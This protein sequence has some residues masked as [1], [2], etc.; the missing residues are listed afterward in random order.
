MADR[1][2]QPC[3]CGSAAA[4]VV[5]VHA[6]RLHETSCFAFR[7]RQL[8]PRDQFDQPDALAAE[9]AAGNLCRRHVGEH[10]QQFVDGQRCN[11]LAEQHARRPLARATCSAPCTSVVTSRASTRCASRF[12]GASASPP[13]ARRSSSR[14]R[15]VKHFRYVD[16]VAIV[17]VQPELIELEGDVRCGSSHIVPASVFPNLAPDAVFISGQTSPWAFCA[18]QLADQIDAGGDVAPLVA[19]AHLQHAAIPIEQLQKI[20]GL[21]HE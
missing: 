11:V 2:R 16:D 10:R 20:V 18:A 5:H 19:A 7:R 17:G 1:P 12:S 14:S 3:A 8:D 6:T 21:Q 4:A 9:F 15:N 13:R